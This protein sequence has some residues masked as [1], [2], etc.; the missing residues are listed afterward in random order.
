M[1]YVLVTGGAQGL[2][3]SI[4]RVFASKGYNVIIGYLNSK[5]SALELSNKLNKEYNV[6]CIVKKIDIT[7]EED[8]KCLFD[9]YD[10]DILINNASLSCDNYIED[11]S[12]DEFMNVL[13]VNLG[14]T[15]LMCKYAK[16]VK[17]VI[18]ISSK[19]GIDTYNPISLDYCS[20][21][22][23]IINL[24]CN[25]SLYYKDK[26]IYCVC[27]GWINT[28]SVSSMNPEYLKSEMKRIG[29][30]TLLD[31]DYVAN[32]IYDLIDSNKKSGSVVIIDE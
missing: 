28:E 20:S 27:P 5:D 29:Q 19:D 13:K 30:D 17:T 1:N 22:A 21:K 7:C 10:I 18:N 16:K 2:G 25:L 6:N 11:K 26:K 14:G 12:F 3:A 8:V 32:K 31:K 24:S 15:Y 9:E 23:G 4:C